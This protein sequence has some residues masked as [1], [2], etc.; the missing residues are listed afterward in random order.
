MKKL[1][2]MGF[3]TLAFASCVSDKEVAPQTQN[4]KYDA[5]FESFVGGKVNANVN[6]GFDDQLV[7]AFG[8]DGNLMRGV[9]ANANE[10]S[11]KMN[12]PAEPTE[13]EIDLVQKW[14]NDNPNPTV[15]V[16]VNWSDFFVF[17]VWTQGYGNQNMDQICCGPNNQELEHINNFNLGGGTD[18]GWH[19]KSMF[20]SNS[21]SLKFTYECSLTDNKHKVYDHFIII[22]G[23]VIDETL[24]GNYYVG[25]DFESDGSTGEKVVPADGNYADYIVRI[26][27]AT[28]KNAKRVM[29]E[30]LIDSNLEN[31]DISDWDFNDAV[32]DV[33]FVQEWNGSKNVDYAIITLWAAG[34]TKKLYVGGKEVHELFGQPVSTMINTNANGGVD[35]LAPVVFRVLLGDATYQDHNA[36]E[37]VTKVNSTE[38]VAKQGESTQ[39]FAVPVGTKWM[40]ERKIITGSYTEF[41]EYVLNNS[42]QDWYNTVSGTQNLY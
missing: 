1:F 15:G 4:Q 18:N 2:L 41:Q 28:Y 26:N 27:P 17:Q 32:F 37:I 19:G 13:S 36:L 12:V 40:K 10:W 8:K 25:F 22:P 5:A 16:V 6:W 7:T 38:L 29:V 31:L 35:G 20:M 24:A 42:P 3:V 21:S 9:W 33:A 14:F 39:K 30:D 34:G 23:S 11:G